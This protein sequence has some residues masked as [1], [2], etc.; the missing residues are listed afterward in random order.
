VVPFIVLVWMILGVVAYFVLRSRTPA[1]LTRIG[2]VMTE[3]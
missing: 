2:D 3:G 1:A